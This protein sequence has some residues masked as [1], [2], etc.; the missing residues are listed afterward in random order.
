MKSKIFHVIAACGVLSAVLVL[1]VGAAARQHKGG[2]GFGPPSPERMLAR[3][4]EDLDLTSDQVTQIKTIM[5]TQESKT[6]PYRTQ[7]ADL[8]AQMRA[9]TANGQFDEAKVREIATQQSQI[10]VELTVERERGRSQTYSVLTADQ[11]AKF[12]QMHKRAGGPPP[13]PPG[14]GRFGFAPEN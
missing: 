13:P 8:D 4:A 5:T 2:P 12:E 10:M 6:E 9:A 1:T 7:L 11:R 14:G 3:M